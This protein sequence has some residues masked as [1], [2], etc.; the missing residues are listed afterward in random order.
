MLNTKLGP[1]T[2][3]GFG[4]KMN[5]LDVQNGDVH[6][7]WTPDSIGYHS[8]DGYVFIGNGQGKKYG[9]AYGSDKNGHNVVGC[10]IDLVNMKAFFTFNGK[11]LKDI[12]LNN[13]K[14]TFLCAVIVVEQ[15]GEL[16][17]NYGDTPF[18]FDLLSA[19]N[20]LKK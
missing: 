5:K 13:M 10:G 6:V 18:T 12:D 7:G 16:T 9:K 3:K 19:I 8:D 1:L 20:E 2:I 14:M 11:R 4:L 15:F 17:I